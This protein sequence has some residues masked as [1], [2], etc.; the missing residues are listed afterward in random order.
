MSILE[1]GWGDGGF[2]QRVNKEGRAFSDST[3]FSRIHDISD[4]IGEVFVLTTAGFVSITSTGTETGV[5]HLKNLDARPLRIHSI[6][7]CG[8]Q[9][10]KVKLYSGVTTGT[11]ISNADPGGEA[12]LNQTSSKEI[13]ADVFVGANGYTVTNGMTVPSHINNVGHSD[14]TFDGAMILG[15]NDSIT[16][17]FEVAIAAD[18]CVRTIAY[19]ETE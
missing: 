2:K 5:F 4:R 10:Q 13:N 8:N 6:R 16:I 7:T 9:I 12:N 3:V 14:E 15:K 11:L 18:V 19:Y 17:T 1:N